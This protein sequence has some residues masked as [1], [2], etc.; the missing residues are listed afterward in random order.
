[1]EIRT[2]EDCIRERLLRKV[3]PDKEKSI[4]SMDRSRKKIK[5]AEKAIEVKIYPYAILEAYNAMFHAARAI[6][7]RDGIQEKSHYAIYI[8]LKEKYEDII[9]KTTSNLL[10]IHRKERH[11]TLYGLEYEPGQGEAKTALEDA[12]TF[13]KQ[14]EKTL[15]ELTK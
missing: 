10:N 5:N 7:Y 11:E 1:M 8:Y 12:K 2:I 14:I 4:K 6:L 13:T 15:K 9:P 3:Q